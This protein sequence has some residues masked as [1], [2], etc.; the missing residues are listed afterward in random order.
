M[1]SAESD[2]WTSAGDEG[3]IAEP[4]EQKKIQPDAQSINGLCQVSQL[5]PNTTEQ[6]ESSLWVVKHVNEIETISIHS[7]VIDPELVRSKS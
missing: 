5:Y 3:G 2:G 4:G 6:A 1:V 7:C